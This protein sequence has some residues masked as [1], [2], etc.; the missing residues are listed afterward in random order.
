MTLA[1]IFSAA[2]KV[3][4]SPVSTTLSSLGMVAGEYYCHGGGGGTL[5]AAI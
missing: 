4:T 1:T 5:Q 2:A 3:S